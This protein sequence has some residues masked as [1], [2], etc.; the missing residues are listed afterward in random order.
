LK[1]VI[2]ILLIS[3]LIIFLNNKIDSCDLCKYEYNGKTL[4]VK[5]VVNIYSDQCFKKNE[6][7]SVDWERFYRD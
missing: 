3:F 5:Q 2:L 4:G 7:L 1:I 6:T